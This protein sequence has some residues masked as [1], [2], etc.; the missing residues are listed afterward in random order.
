VEESGSNTRETP[1][2]PKDADDVSAD[3]NVRD[4]EAV[5]AGTPADLV[6]GAPDD[7]TIDPSVRADQ[8]PQEEDASGPEAPSDEGLP[9]EPDTAD[10][11]AENGEVVPAPEEPADAQNEDTLV[12]T[13]EPETAPE[14]DP[15]RISDALASIDRRLDE[16]ARLSKRQADLLRQLHDENQRLRQGELQSAML[17]LLRDLMRLLD[18]V[19]RLL[20]IDGSKDLKLV[21][22]ALTD[23]LGRNG[24]SPFAPAARD[25]YDSAR[26][27]AAGVVQAADEE[28]DRT[29][30]SVR[31]TG[32]QRDDG[33][34]VRAADVVVWKYKSP[35]QPAETEPS[36]TPT[37][38][39]SPDPQAAVDPAA[40]AAVRAPEEAPAHSQ[41]TDPPIAIEERN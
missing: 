6:A 24:V 25:P 41:V 22:D 32:F 27:A 35:V 28:L 3:I 1:M 34:I 29:I 23:A 2:P 8:P 5:T 36:E 20:A 9:A 12:A 21:A 14:P 26:H 11:A 37:G 38:T 18:D 40:A 10:A 16:S 7:S 19:D 30:E 33:S 39:S 13:E 15:A 17:P 31:R 4:P